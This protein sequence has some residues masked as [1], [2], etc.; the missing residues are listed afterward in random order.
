[1]KITQN[2]RDYAEGLSY[3]A[4]LEYNGEVTPNTGDLPDSS[5]LIKQVNTELVGKVGEADFDTVRDGMEEMKQKFIKEGKQ[6]YKEVWFFVAWV[7]R[8]F[9]VTHRML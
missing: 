9:G 2:V 5:H 4:G 3:A 6:L 1:M 7:S 8:L